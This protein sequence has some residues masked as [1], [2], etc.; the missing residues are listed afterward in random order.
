MDNQF[1]YPDDNFL[2]VLRYSMCKHMREF[3]S[4]DCVSRTMRHVFE[5]LE[6]YIKSDK[7]LLEVMKFELPQTDSRMLPGHSFALESPVAQRLREI[8]QVLSGRAAQYIENR[9]KHVLNS[10]PYTIHNADG[11]GQE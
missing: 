4:E 3:L 6:P 2:R 11:G 10:H 7:M 1:F 8:E 9:H 5:D